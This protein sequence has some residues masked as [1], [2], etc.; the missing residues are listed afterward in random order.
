[1][2]QK[3]GDVPDVTAIKEES[4]DTMPEEVQTS[5]LPK[6]TFAEIN[7]SRASYKVCNSINRLIQ[8]ILIINSI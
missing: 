4:K 1:M 2:L 5:K 3:S 6:R 8:L 7:A